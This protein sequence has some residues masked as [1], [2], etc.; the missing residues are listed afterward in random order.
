M[1]PLVINDFLLYI[2]SL[3]NALDCFNSAHALALIIHTYVVPYELTVI[4]A[5]AVI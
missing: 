3:I 2:S 1:S 5:H 4:S